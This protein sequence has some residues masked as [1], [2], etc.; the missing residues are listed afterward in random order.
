MHQA[1]P[2]SA[3][4]FKLA[5]QRLSSPL[6]AVDPRLWQ[7]RR[8][9]TNLSNASRDA[10]PSRRMSFGFG[11]G[12]FIAVLELVMEPVVSVTHELTFRRQKTHPRSKTKR[13][14]NTSPVAA[15]VASPSQ[16]LDPGPRIRPGIGQIWGRCSPPGRSW[17]I[18][19]PVMIRVA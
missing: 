3:H 6:L 16:N 1:A 14:S 5:P 17:P 13:I 18:C 10:L 2:S 9:L 12:D 8:H 11:I 7:Y 4:W 15:A 19:D